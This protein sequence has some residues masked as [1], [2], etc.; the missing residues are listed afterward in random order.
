MIVLLNFLGLACSHCMPFPSPHRIAH[1]PPLRLCGLAVCPA[2]EARGSQLLART[3]YPHLRALTPPTARRIATVR[4]RRLAMSSSSSSS[5]SGERGGKK[6][7]HRHK[8]ARAKTTAG[9]TAAAAQAATQ[10]AAHK[11]LRAAKQGDL[12][13]VLDLPEP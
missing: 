12:H 8:H 7:K 4:A 11:F 2:T 3:S 9:Q 6:K 1:A 5:S 13:K 10:Q